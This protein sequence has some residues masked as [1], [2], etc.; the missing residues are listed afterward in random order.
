MDKKIIITI[1]AV[2]FISIAF[3]SCCPRANDPHS[4]GFVGGLQGIFCGDYDR[5]IEQRRADLSQEN[6]QTRRLQ[7]DFNEREKVYKSKVKELQSA[8]QHREMLNKY[9]KSLSS[10]ISRLNAKSAV[11]RSKLIDMKSKISKLQAEID[12]Q[13][14][15]GGNATDLERY[16]VLEKK[17]DILAAEYKALLE[18]FNS[19]SN[20]AE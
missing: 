8:Q 9:I 14:T 4:G 15:D 3:L 6:E 17:R 18:N 5:R 16:R 12:S 10:D 2:A 7:A 1:S 13:K 11:Q 19:L 20:V